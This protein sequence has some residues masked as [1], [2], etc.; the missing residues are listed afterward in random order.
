M[1]LNKI[2]RFRNRIFHNESICWNIDRVTSIRTSLIVVM[3]WINS[4]ITECIKTIDRF[5]VVKKKVL[6]CI[7]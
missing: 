7:Y 5:E 1:P 3:C 2:R 4:D 6:Q